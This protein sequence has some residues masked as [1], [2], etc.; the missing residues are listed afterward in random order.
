MNVARLRTHEAFYGPAALGAP[1]DVE[2]FIRCSRGMRVRA[3][4]WIT[5]DRGLERERTENGERLGQITDEVPQRAFYRQWYE[6]IA[7]RTGEAAHA[8]GNGH[9]RAPLLPS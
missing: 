1:D 3:R 2:M 7:A 4:E 8:G 9:T 5:F 6:L